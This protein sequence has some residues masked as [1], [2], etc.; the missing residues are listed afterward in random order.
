MEICDDHKDYIFASFYVGAIKQ[1]QQPGT[2]FIFGL[3][4]ESNAN[5]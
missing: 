3:K 4:W 2:I 5:D 1:G